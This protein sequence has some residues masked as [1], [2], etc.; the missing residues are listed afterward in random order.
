MFTS[1]DTQEF[2]VKYGISRGTPWRSWLRHCAGSIRD[3]VIGILP[4][5]EISTW[6]TSWGGGGLVRGANNLSTFM[7]RLFKI[8]GSINPLEPQGPVQASNGIALPLTTTKGSVSDILRISH[9]LVT[10]LRQIM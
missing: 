9:R 4:R 8:S 7:C 2:Y 10:T 3:E 6:N 1:R 5:T